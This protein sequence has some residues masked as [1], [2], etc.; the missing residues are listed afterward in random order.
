[1]TSRLLMVLSG[2]AVLAGLAALLVAGLGLGPAAYRPDWLGPAGSVA[3]GAV[4]TAALAARTGGR[5][6]VFGTLALLIGVG[7]V[8]V[9]RPVLLTGAAASTCVVAAVLAIVATV[10]AVTALGA[11]REAILAG[12]IAAVGAVATVG[13]GPSLDIARFEYVTLG[14]ALFGAFLVIYRLGAG[15][16]GIGTRG[17]LT[18]LV[19]SVLLA[20]TLAYAELLRRYG[21]PGLVAWLFD[22][23]RWS[24]AHLGA[25]PRP[26]VALLG[27][28]A[29][30]WGTHM[31]ARRRQ[32]WWVCAF[33]AAATA[34]IGSALINPEVTRTES[35]L[36]VAYAIVVGL[37]VGIV[38]IRLDLRVS[39]PRG[40]RS[41][42]GGAGRRAAERATAVRPEPQ[43]TQALL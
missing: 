6:Y 40:A 12:M 2:V 39:R 7:V 21:M 5:P 13:L 31:R 36:A 30:T 43:R 23:V 34:P 26:I 33:G 18:V 4:F 17:L 10:P 19:G 35:V 41:S 9:D 29:L 16:H 38:V 8:V 24:R 20:V 28:P 37:L 22:A 32:G 1:L 15:F 25:F 42:G 3:V 27:I 14:G 11:A